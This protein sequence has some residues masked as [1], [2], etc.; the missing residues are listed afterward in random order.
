LGWGSS[1]GGNIYKCLKDWVFRQWL[2]SRGGGRFR[3]GSGG[4]FHDGVTLKVGHR[5]GDVNDLWA[6]KQAEDDPITLQVLILTYPGAGRNG[7]HLGER[8][9]NFILSPGEVGSIF[10]D[11]SSDR[12]GVH[13]S[14]TTGG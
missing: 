13:L 11:D 4:S 9:E 5:G 14:N 1:G 10:L 8:N 3:R 2:G 7:L 6:L 12:G